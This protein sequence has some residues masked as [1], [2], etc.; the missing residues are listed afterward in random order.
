MQALLDLANPTNSL[1]A[2]QLFHDSVENHIRSLSAL[3]SLLVPIILDKLPAETRRN[4][5][6][7]HENDEWTM[8]Q[9]AVLKEI[10][11]LEMGIENPLHKK[12][13]SPIPTASFHTG[14]S[15]KPVRKP[16]EKKLACVYCK[17]SHASAN[18]NTVKEYKERLDII[19]R[20]KL[21]YNCLGHHKVS[22]CS[23]KYCCRKCA[24]KH[25]TSV[26]N[27]AGDPGES[28]D[29]SQGSNTKNNT[30]TLSTLTPSSCEPS[31]SRVCLLK[32]AIATITTA[33][34]EAEANILFDEGS[35]RSFLTQELSDVLSL[36]SHTS[37]NI[38]L[39]SFGGK[40]PLNKRM[41]VAS[42]TIKTRTGGLIPISVLIVPTIATPLR[43]TAKTEIT[44][45]PYSRGLPLAHP[46]TTDDN[47]KISLLIGA[48]YYWDMVEDHIVRGN[49]PTAMASKLKYL[50]SGPLSSARS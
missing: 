13:S 4:L 2:L 44:M 38:C 23:S 21:C 36:Q 27:A 5:A 42:I 48:D 49:G 37:E 32:T 40:R 7:D 11:I 3:G 26:C 20:D 25:H 34:S 41:E 31:K 22:E 19:K 50:L 10:H 18:C 9:G 8:L 6:R 35:Q 29:A 47:F 45:L 24:R 43:N 12:M 46:I 15:R 1:A 33:D 16:T 30:T 14:S 39:S 28:K 17:G